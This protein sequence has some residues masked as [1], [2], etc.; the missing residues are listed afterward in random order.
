LN[1]T[2]KHAQAGR[3]DIRLGVSQ[4]EIELELTDDGV[5]FDPRAEYSGHMGLNSMRERAA[6]IGGI[7]EIASEVGHGA[8]IRVRI[9]ATDQPG[10]GVP[11][12]M[13]DQGQL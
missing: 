9:P 1:N 13:P 5:G 10:A 6:Q 7:L 2:V 8:V 11:M 4:G 3:V 12:P